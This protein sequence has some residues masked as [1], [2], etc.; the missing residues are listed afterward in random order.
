MSGHSAA[1]LVGCT[2]FQ[3]EGKVPVGLEVRGDDEREILCAVHSETRQKL[4]CVDATR[5]KSVL[6]RLPC[7]HEEPGRA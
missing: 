2:L 5:T 4:L 6:D 3:H 1:R 7:A